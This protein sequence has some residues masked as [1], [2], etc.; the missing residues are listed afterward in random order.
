MKCPALRGY[1]IDQF[2]LKAKFLKT[3]KL[4]VEGFYK[5]LSSCNCKTDVAAY[6]Q[7]RFDKNR[8]KLFTF[9]DYDGVPWNNNNAEHTIKA[10]AKLRRILE[11]EIEDKG[12]ND[13]IIFLSICET[14][15]YKGVS[16]LDFLRSGEKDVDHFISRTGA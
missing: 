10:F 4:S 6:Y 14:C 1:P 8:N 5:R 13:Y 9:L 11:H 15:R 3:H 2:G 12:I 16:F 7:E